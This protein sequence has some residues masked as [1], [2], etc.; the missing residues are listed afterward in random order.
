MKGNLLRLWKETRAEKMGPC[1]K[2]GDGPSIL[3]I[4]RNVMVVSNPV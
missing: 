2:G 4:A 3:L 1:V